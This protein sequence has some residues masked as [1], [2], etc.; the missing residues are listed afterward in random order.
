[1]KK[2]LFMSALAL[3]LALS[4]CSTVQQAAA[5]TAAP[6]PSAAPTA[7]PRPDPE[8]GEQVYA[9]A[10]AV[11]GREEPVLSP[12]YRLPEIENAGGIASYEAVNAYY[13]QALSDLAAAAAELSGYAVEDSSIAQATGDPFYPYVDTETYEITLQSAGRVSFLRS[14]YS[15]MGG[16]YPTLYP[17]GDTFDLTTGTRLS[18]ADLFSVSAD[19][20][21]ARVL[22]GVIAQNAGTGYDPAALRSAY[23]PEQFYLTEDSLVVYYQEGTLGPHAVGAPTFA[24]PYADLEEILLTWE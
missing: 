8:W 14:H 23:V 15:N 5:P 16:P 13:A 19:E 2:R 3:T 24:V 17:L 11:E 1:M 10:Y 21:Q 9:T 18:F 7:A 22:D 12:E 4:G 6:A 20:A